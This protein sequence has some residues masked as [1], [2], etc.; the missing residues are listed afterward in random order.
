MM[1]SLAADAGLT[2]GG[3]I[4]M[5]LSVGFVTSLFVWC[6]W[7]VLRSPDASEHMHSQMD[8]ETP[9]VERES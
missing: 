2:P 6:I 9:D 1:S 5:I 3:W 7:R 4:T 8:I